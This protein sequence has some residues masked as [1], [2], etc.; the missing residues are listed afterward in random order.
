MTGLEVEGLVPAI[1]NFMVWW[2]NSI[3]ILR[4][5]SKCSVQEDRCRPFRIAITL[6]VAEARPQGFEMPPLLGHPPT[7]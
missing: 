4:Q 6:H 7:R 3:F 1:A 2:I 5:N